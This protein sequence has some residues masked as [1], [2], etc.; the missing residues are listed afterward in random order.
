[1]AVL[2][3]LALILSYWMVLFLIG[4]PLT[5][6]CLPRHRQWIIAPL[7]PI[8]GMALVS[9]AYEYWFFLLLQPYRPL[10]V[11][12]AIAIFSLIV[13]GAALLVRGER[14]ALV[15]QDLLQS[16]ARAWPLTVIPVLGA[17][18]FSAFFWSNG[19]EMLSGAEDELAYAEVTRYI[20]DHLFTR[21]ALDY[22]WGRSDHYLADF[23]AH[24]LAYL[25]ETRL[26]AFFLLADLSSASG[27]STERAF[28]VLAGTGIA[29]ATASL[30]IFELFVRR[31][32]IA[33]LAAQLAFVGASVLVM[34]HIQ[35]SL[36]HLV[37][38]GARLGGLAYIFW[39][40][41]YSLT[42]APLLLGGLLGAG[43]L[44]LYH[45]SIGFGLVLP[46]AVSFVGVLWRSYR[47]R[48]ALLRRFGLRTA[49]LALLIYAMQPDLI[50]RVIRQHGW[51]AAQT[52]KFDIEENPVT[53]LT[54]ANATAAAR[55]PP[56]LGIVSLYDDGDLSFRL[57][58]TLGSPP[59]LPALFILAALA[60]VGFWYRL[61]AGAREGWA[62]MPVLLA[63]VTLAASV[64]ENGVIVIRGA[65]MAMPPIFVGLSL[66][67]FAHRDFLG[68]AGFSSWSQ[69]VGFFGR[70]S[71][72]IL[73]V[74]LVGINGFAVARSLIHANHFSRETDLIL[75]HYDPD[76]PLWTEFRE[77]FGSSDPA[78]VL[79]SGFKD[80]PTPHMIAAGLR[81]VPHLVGQSITAFWLGIDPTYSV[82]RDFQNFRHW[83]T[84]S[85][86][87]DRIKDD[88]VSNWP[89]TYGLLLAHARQAIV[90]VSG[91][92]P[93]EWGEWSAL[94]GPR[95]WRFPNLCDVLD[96][97][98]SAFAPEM[99]SPEAGRDELGPFWRAE[100]PLKARLRLREPAVAVVELGYSGEPPRISIDGIAMSERSPKML[101]GTKMFFAI[102][103][104]VGPDSE[105]EV[106][107]SAETKLRS[108]GLYRLPSPVR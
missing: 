103:A 93:A 13:L 86:L 4:L 8:V 94:W 72:G 100:H 97:T 47:G 66:L 51:H 58:H 75:R 90:P 37:S 96:R 76:A 105:I 18:G 15:G 21:D 92:Y 17:A 43:W 69:R 60:A 42:T 35:G 61:P 49:A 45:E 38:L 52:L 53:A 77:L 70:I 89:Q 30:G 32:R 24:Y 78:P 83:L 39:A 48:R 67:A 84:P 57:M 23:T 74:A 46:L 106:F 80:T 56:V 102:H 44:I 5:L 64:Y 19:L 63:G 68:A 7:S 29:I 73:W 31:S 36:S 33:V 14:L 41:A 11:H 55:L 107:T 101:S 26:G 65:Q 50:A 95:A 59:P 20:M 85:G 1:M 54:R 2:F 12:S 10:V 88:P 27:L 104:T 79:L 16:L 22:P 28:P 40:C 87:A 71:T 34:L 3:V 99:E 62:A 98:E 91:A 9:C 6:A 81:T 108:I 82:A 25:P